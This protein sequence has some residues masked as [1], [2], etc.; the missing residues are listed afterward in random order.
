MTS[1]RDGVPYL[2][3]VFAAGVGLG[4]V[5]VRWPARGSG[6]APRSSSSCR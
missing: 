5:R 1:L 3:W 6:C 4:V 2:A